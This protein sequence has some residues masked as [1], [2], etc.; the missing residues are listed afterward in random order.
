MHGKEKIAIFIPNPVQDNAGVAEISQNLSC[1]SLKNFPVIHTA[2]EVNSYDFLL[3]V[4]E[5]GLALRALS[6][7]NMKPVR[8]D[9]ASGAMTHRRMTSCARQNIAKAVGMK[10][11]YRPLILDATSG[12]GTDAFVLASLGCQMIMLE[13]N[14]IVANLLKNGIDRAAK[15]HD[16]SKIICRMKLIEQ[17]AIMY[18]QSNE[19]ISTGRPDVVYLD[20]MFPVRTKSAQVKKEMRILQMLLAKQH[21]DD[22][23][24]F[25][26][27][28]NTASRRVVVKRPR[29]ANTIN[30]QKPDIQFTDKS[31]RFDV[32][33]TGC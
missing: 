33:L 6:F 25:D 12:L 17:D 26:A 5:K 7:P 21:E 1:C 4:D 18:M 9:F 31:C 28:L 27:A 23:A 13:K 24:L 11:N 10:G 19:L 16:L 22:E 30:A 32:Y 8:V 15:I 2:A 20:P 14:A 3:I 29:L